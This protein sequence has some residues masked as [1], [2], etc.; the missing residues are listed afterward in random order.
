MIEGRY[1]GTFEGQKVFESKM[2]GNVSGNYRGLTVP[3][4]GIIVGKGVF[5]SGEPYGKAMMQHEF[6]HILQYKRVGSFAYWNV[7]VPE[8]FSS[9]T[10]TSSVSHGSFWTETWAN[11][12]SKEYFGK[13]WIGQKFGYPVKNI[14]ISN[15]L[16][17]RVVKNMG[18]IPLF[19]I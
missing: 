17:L 6:G 12:L 7:I 3:E 8:S 14:S 2:L 5:T 18:L 11:Y 10:F 13:R 9:A 15:M 4:R 16:R 1:V 19:M